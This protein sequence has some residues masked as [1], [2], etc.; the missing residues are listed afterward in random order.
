MNEMINSKE[1]FFKACQGETNLKRPP[2][3]F[4]R[5]AG[6]YLPEYQAVRKK[7]KFLELCLN[8]EW[9]AEVSVQP[10]ELIGVD[11][12]IIFSDILLPLNDFG[13]KVDFPESGGISIHSPEQ[14]IGKFELGEN[15]KATC[16]AISTLHKKL[17]AKNLEVPV[18]GFAG[19]PWTLLNYILEGGSSK[20]VGEFIKAKQLILNNPQKAHIWLQA[21]SELSLKYLQ[22]QIKAGAEAVQ[23]FDTWAGELTLEEFE[24]FVL[25][26]LK[27]IFEQIPDTVP[28]IFYMKGIS[29]YLEIA[30]NCGASIISLDWKISLSKAETL[31]TNSK[32]KCLQG[33]LDPLVLTTEPKIVL[34][35]TKKII[36][37]GQKIKFGHI[38]NL[39]HGI[40]PN[41]KVENT[42]AFVKAAHE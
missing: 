38:L 8:P 23:L 17:K 18:L 28:K 4:M 20:R 21:L 34:Q 41:A 16:A 10:V 37:E 26:Y 14:P 39:G 7:F 6:R 27:S 11:A 32:V 1:L 29:P 9:A 36:A 31:I 30:Q 33:N 25:P 5:Q 2:V 24:N 22:A 12:A 42:K 40:M 19:A 13:I 35:Q 15:S 3:W